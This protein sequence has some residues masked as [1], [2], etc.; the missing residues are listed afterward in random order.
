LTASG[1][2]VAAGIL[3]I[4]IVLDP[5]GLF[6][7]VVNENSNDISVYAVDPA[8]GVLTA[9]ANSP[10]GTGNEPRAIAID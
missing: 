3:P 9:A 7:Y 1:S 5:L 4:D 8:S 6:A 2:P 10:V